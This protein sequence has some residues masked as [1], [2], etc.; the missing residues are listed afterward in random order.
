MCNKRVNSTVYYKLY[1]IVMYQY[2][3]INCT[4]C[5][6][7]IQDENNRGNCGGGGVTV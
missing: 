5:T 6:T 3:P 4:K 1:L 2:W 7:L